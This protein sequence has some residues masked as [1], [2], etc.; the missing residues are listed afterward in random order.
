VG[1]FLR[2]DKIGE[3]EKRDRER[4]GGRENGRREGERR[5]F[6]LGVMKAGK[7]SGRRPWG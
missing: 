5:S 7:G 2:E 1:I 6:K 4:E 3:E